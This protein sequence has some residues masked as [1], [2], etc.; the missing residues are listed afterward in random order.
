MILYVSI[1]T[2]EQLKEAAECVLSPYIIVPAHLAGRA[3]SV[4]PLNGWAGII[5]SLPEVAREN[6]LGQLEETVAEAEKKG[7]GVLIRNTDELGLVKS[8]G[9]T[10]R[11][12]AD[13][14]LYAYNSQAVGCYLGLLPD[15][16]FILPDEMSD[17]EF[18]KLCGNIPGSAGVI[19]KVYGKQ[20]LMTTAQNMPEMDGA[21][22]ITFENAKNDRFISIWDPVSEYTEIFNAAP[23]SMLDK[24]AELTW[25][26][27]LAEFTVETGR[28]LKDAMKALEDFACGRHVR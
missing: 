17:D 21:S 3:V 12:I 23:T 18:N 14:S 10:G 20:R 11:V 24:A 26:S 1:K 2:E 6:K 5:V 15:M 28:E 16:M 7:Y 22:S 8:S 19:Y 13:S 4:A 9:F 27:F 25:D